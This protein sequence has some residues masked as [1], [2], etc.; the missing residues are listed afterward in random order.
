VTAK[1]RL[2]V[3]MGR[4]ACSLSKNALKELLLFGACVMLVASTVAQDLVSLLLYFSSPEALVLRLP[5]GDPFVVAYIQRGRRE[6]CGRR[7]S[8]FRFG[9]QLHLLC[10]LLLGRLPPGALC[11][12]PPSTHPSALS[13]WT[14]G[15]RVFV[16][17]SRV[18][19]CRVVALAGGVSTSCG[20]YIR[21]WMWSALSWDV[22]R[23]TCC[24]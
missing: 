16:Q 9:S 1:L 18:V 20:I 8:L 6:Q 17:S 2:R 14:A 24:T 13:A 11:L 5:A 3:A 19:S 10:A 7:G 23:L 12:V 21:E 15:E 22:C 4:L